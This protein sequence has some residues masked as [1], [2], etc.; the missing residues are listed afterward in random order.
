[1]TYAFN[2]TFK[3]FGIGSEHET[4]E[5]VLL[6]SLLTIPLLFLLY[7]PLII[8]GFYAVLIGLDVLCFTVT[9][10]PLWRVLLLEWLLIV[11][12]F[13]WWAFVY[14]YWLW[15]ALALSF[16]LT[17]WMRIPKIARILQAKH[18]A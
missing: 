3:V 16:L 8:G 10:L 12:I 13:I 7:G 11:P 1:M 2:I 9:R 15:L 14:H 4:W 5:S 6:E 17:Q 18:H